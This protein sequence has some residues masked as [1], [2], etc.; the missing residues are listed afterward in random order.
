[1]KKFE[2]ACFNL[3]SAI[4]AQKAGAD[5]VELCATISVGGTTPII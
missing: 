3:E 5:R 2:I 1:M 4:L